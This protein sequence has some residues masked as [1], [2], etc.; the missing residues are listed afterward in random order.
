MQIPILNGI[1]VDNTPELRTSYPI[2]LVPV[3]IESG[4]SGG[5]LRQGDGIVA[6]GSGPGIDRG[7]IGWNCDSRRSL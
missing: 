5:F 7:G 4:I 2:N 3:P 6:N 1:F